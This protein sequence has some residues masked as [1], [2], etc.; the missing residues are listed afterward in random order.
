[1]AILAPLLIEEKLQKV[2]LVALPLAA[3]GMVLIVL[4][5][6]GLRWGGEH[7][8]GIIAGT[9]SGFAYA[10]IIVMSRK[11]SMMHLHYTSVILLLWITVVATAPTVLS[12][13]IDITWRVGI[14]LLTGGIAHSTVAPLLYFSALRNVMAQHAAI[15]G[16]IEPLA[17]VPL[18][19]LF[20]SEIPSLS[21][22]AGGVLIILSG[23]LVVHDAAR[24]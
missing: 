22:I 8:G 21:S 17:A 10:I 11:L 24:R 1:V 9:A 5:G 16:Y 4:S 15:L 6:G 2:T 3:A 18:A 23:Y 7:T 14:L 12:S 19:V 13:D 20:L